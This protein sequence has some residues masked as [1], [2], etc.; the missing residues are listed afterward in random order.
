MSVRPGA[1]VLDQFGVRMVAP[2]G[3]RLNQHWLV[4]KG[5]EQLVLRRWSQPLTIFNTN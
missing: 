5:R 1:E 3:G 2:L 4:V